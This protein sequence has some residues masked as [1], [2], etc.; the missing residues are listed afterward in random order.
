MSTVLT[1]PHVPV[2]RPRATLTALAR[3]DARRFARHPLF[4]FGA[5]TIAV[6]AVIQLVQQSGGGGSPIAAVVVIAFLIGVFGFVVAHRLTTSMRRT[7]ELAGTAPVG[8]QQRTAALCLACLVPF[9]VGCVAT[10]FLLVTQIVWTPVGIPASAH[11]ASFRDEPDLALVTAILAMAP[12]A[13][14]GGPLLGVAVARWAPF[15]GSALVGVVALLFVCSVDAE[16]SLPWNLL[17]PWPILYE[18]RIGEDTA[19][20]ATSWLLPGISPT[21]G[22]GL[23]AVSVRPG[24]RGRAPARPG[25]PA[26]AAVDRRRADCRRSRLLRDGGRVSLRLRPPLPVIGS[27]AA[28]LVLMAL[29]VALPGDGVSPFLMRLVELVLAAGA[30]YLLDEGAADMATVSPLT[31]WRRRAPRLVV[32]TALLAAAWGGVLLLLHGQVTPQSLVAFTCELIVIAALAV[33]TASVLAWRGD[34]EP[35]GRVASVVGIAGLTALVAQLLVPT[36]IFLPEEGN[37]AGSLVV[38][39][40]GVGLLAVGVTLLASRDPASR[41]RG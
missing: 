35:G 13:T 17:A 22:A 26:T 38:V 39:W 34:P 40:A 1:T 37:P 7:A 10:A 36:A 20:L 27:M 21:V 16:A 12:V 11:V 32:G 5:G 18:E 23:H 3:A 31:L 8:R 9:A 4:L 30:A 28:A 2:V 29:V 33:A 14:L 19:A 24:R 25:Q 41:W 6:L 15:R